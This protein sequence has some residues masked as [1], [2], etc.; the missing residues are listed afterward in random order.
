[1]ANGKMLRAALVATPAVLAALAIEDDA[2]GPEVQDTTVKVGDPAAQGDPA[3]QRVGRTI[4]VCTSCHDMVRFDT[5]VQR[6]ACNTLVPVNTAECTHSGGAQ[7]EGSCAS[8]HAAG[9]AFD[10]ARVHPMTEKPQ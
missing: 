6:P 9:G 7:A 5:N 8:C 3:E 2:V 10:T 1:M 4:A